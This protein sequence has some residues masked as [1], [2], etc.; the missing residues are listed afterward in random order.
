MQPSSPQGI[1]NVCISSHDAYEAGEDAGF[2]E[3]VGAF[4]YSIIKHK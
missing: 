4:F 2:L 1:K 3:K